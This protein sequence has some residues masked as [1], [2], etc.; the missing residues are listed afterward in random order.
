MVL[1]LKFADQILYLTIFKE[2]KPMEYKP[3]ELLEDKQ[4]EYKLRIR[5]LVQHVYD[6]DFF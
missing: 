5:N 1:K 4:E 2:Y 6:N 3:M